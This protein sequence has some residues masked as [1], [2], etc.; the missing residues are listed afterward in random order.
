MLARTTLAASLRSD[1]RKI[2]YRLYYEVNGR[3]FCDSDGRKHGG[4][5]VF[6]YNL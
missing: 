1:L 6:P 4:L 2:Q 3:V 5:L